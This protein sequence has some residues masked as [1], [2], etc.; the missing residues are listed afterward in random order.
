MSA[1]AMLGALDHCVGFFAGLYETGRLVI[2]RG[3]KV[4][5][6]GCAEADWLTPMKADRPDLHLTGLDQRDPGERPGADV[7]VRADVRDPQVF[8]PASFDVIVAISVL[9]HVGIGRYGD[10]IDPDGD[11]QTMRNLEAWLRPHGLLYLDVPYRGDG[12]STPFR[13]Y[14]E[15]DVQRR[16]IGSWTVVD[17]QE[18]AGLRPNGTPHPDGPYLALVLRP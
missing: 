13:A 16:I 5:E 3:V 12:P 17:R 6:I 11:M 4:L 8:A 14:S 7:V 9:E 18:F 1:L 2:P 10:P 15:R